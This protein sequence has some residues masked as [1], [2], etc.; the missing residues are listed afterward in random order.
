MAM[1]NMESLLMRITIRINE[2]KDKEI[3]DILKNV[4]D[5]TK[6]VKYFLNKGIHQNSIFID[7]NPV[8][9]ELEECLNPMP[10]TNKET[11]IEDFKS[12][13]LKNTF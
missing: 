4:K 11:S 9:L 13:L 7:T 6:V 10:T 2:K 3:Y 8:S 5:R 12:N 1:P